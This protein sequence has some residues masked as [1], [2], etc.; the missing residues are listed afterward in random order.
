[1][2]DRTDQRS[3]KL[4]E[5]IDQ[6]KASVMTTLEAISKEFEIRRD[7]QVRPQALTFDYTEGLKVGING[8]PE[9]YNTTDH[10]AGQVFDRVGM[11]R[12]YAAKLATLDRQDLILYNLRQLAPQTIEDGALLRTVG[13]QLKGFL[14]P[15]FRRMDASPILEGFLESA[16]QQGMVPYSGRNTDYRMQVQMVYPQVMQPAPNE[17]IAMGAS[18]TT[19]DYGQ[20]ALAVNMMILR[21]TCKN[22]ATG[23]DL[24]RRVHLGGRCQMG[25]KEII[26]ISD[27]THQLDG[28]TVA[29]AVRDVVKGAADQARLLESAVTKA[30]NQEITEDKAK[31]IYETLKKRGIRKEDVETI[32]AQYENVPDSVDLLPAGKSLWRMSNAI[33]LI[34]NNGKLSQDRK[35]DLENEAFNI[36]GIDK[37][38]GKPQAELIN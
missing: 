37:N 24:F 14:S 34:A 10:S 13:P 20:Q 23:L 31:A 8:E 22:L 12:Q 3:A 32:K 35:I 4:Q 36:L 17:F 33:S 5:Y 7:R 1:M 21:I 9:T 15:A 26:E 27:R 18:L 30:A 29:S 11:P 6:G 25:E 2:L 19:G 28:A 38:A 16:L